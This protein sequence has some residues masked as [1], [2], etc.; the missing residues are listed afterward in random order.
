[1][2][3]YISFTFSSCFKEKEPIDKNKA[4]KTYYI[5]FPQ[6]VRLKIWIISDSYPD[7]LK[8]PTFSSFPEVFVGFGRKFTTDEFLLPILRNEKFS[9]LGI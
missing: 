9:F 3:F 8:N 1:M 2:S 7:L 5:D 4:W 6:V